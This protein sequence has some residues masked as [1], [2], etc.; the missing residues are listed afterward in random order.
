MHG[1]LSQVNTRIILIYIY[2]SLRS[3]LMSIHCP[4][5]NTR[6]SGNTTLCFRQ[7]I[8]IPIGR[9][10]IIQIMLTNVFH[11]EENLAK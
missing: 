9:N 6:P 5:L 10:V 2:L 1:P 7:V 3:P 11:A 4:T 8:K